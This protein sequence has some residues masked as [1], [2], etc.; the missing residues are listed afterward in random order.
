FVDVGFSGTNFEPPDFKRL[1]EKIDNDEVITVIVKDMSR[2]G[3]DFLKVGYYTE[4]AFLEAKIRFIAITNG[5]DSNKQQ[6]CEFKPF[7]IL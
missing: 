3:R 5:V 6:D 2:L 4:M 1:V 7:L